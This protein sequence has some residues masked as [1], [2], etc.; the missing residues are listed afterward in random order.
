ML[1]SKADK[2]QAMPAPPPNEP[3]VAIAQKEDKNTETLDDIELASQ[4]TKGL[5]VLVKKIE[6]RLSEKTNDQKE[7]DEKMTI[8]KEI[9]GEIIMGVSNAEKAKIPKIPEAPKSQ[10]IVKKVEPS[11]ILAESMT[12]ED[13]QAE[14]K[15]DDKERTNEFMDM[16]HNFKSSYL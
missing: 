16:L 11:K 1:L 8:A 6:M 5:Q 9:G 15:E 10:N 3:K 7:D 13:L 4:K 14:A 12:E 2:V